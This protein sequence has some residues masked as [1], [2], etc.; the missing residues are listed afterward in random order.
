MLN[1]GPK[2]HYHL[3]VKQGVV[4]DNDT[5]LSSSAMLP[6]TFQAPGPAEPCPCAPASYLS[7]WGWRS[8]A[9]RRRE[10]RQRLSLALENRA[11][12]C[13]G[14]RSRLLLPLPQQNGTAANS[15]GHLTKD[16]SSR[17]E[18]QHQLL[19][20]PETSTLRFFIGFY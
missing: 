2:G 11:I 18:S 3:P 13:T 4:Q 8:A 7:G 5:S 15:Q 1:A 17:A 16:I 10:R 9:A 19:T 14:P 12:S 20:R 6:P